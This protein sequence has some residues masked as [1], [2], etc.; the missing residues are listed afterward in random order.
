MEASVRQ[1]AVPAAARALTALD[2]A[3]YEDAFVVVSPPAAT[4]SAVDWAQAVLEEAPERQRREVR[5]AWAALGLQLAPAGSRD[6]V[7][8]WH[9]RRAEGEVAVLAASSPLG[10]RGELVFA[11]RPDGLLYATFVRLAGDDARRAWARVRP[12]HPPV[13]RELLER[14]ASVGQVT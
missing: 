11:S 12:A 8:G 13:V 14:A 2:P 7:L 10:I 1:I 9:L 5:G 3:D 4:R 6:A